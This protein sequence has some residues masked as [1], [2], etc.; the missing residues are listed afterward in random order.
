ML[1][2]SDNLQVT[3]KKI[4]NSEFKID[5]RFKILYSI[6]MISVISGHLGGKASLEFK[7]ILF[8]ISNLYI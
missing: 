4:T 6:A 7:L 3:N 2:E 8:N 5:Y 1:Q